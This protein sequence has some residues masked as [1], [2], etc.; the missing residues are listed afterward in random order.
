MQSGVEAI[1]RPPEHLKTRTPE[2][3]KTGN[4]LTMRRRLGLPT[5][6]ALGFWLLSAGVARGAVAPAAAPAKLTIE[7][8]A[9]KLSGR[10]ATQRFL[11]VGHYA[12]GHARDLTAEAKLAKTGG[13][14]VEGNRVVTVA[15]G[16]ATVTAVVGAARATLQVTVADVDQ[17]PQWSFANEIVP[18]F[19]KAGCNSGGCHGSPSG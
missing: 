13:I 6:L 19:T 11:V 16:P 5:G 9:I 12:D 1:Y 2:H 3:L 10:G 4:E 14:H 18:I 15:N 8:P 7:P 17:E